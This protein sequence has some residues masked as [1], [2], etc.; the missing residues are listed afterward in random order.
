MAGGLLLKGNGLNSK[1]LRKAGTGP[2]FTAARGEALLTGGTG[3]RIADHLNMA[4]QR[5]R[6]LYYMPFKPL[7]HPHPSG[8]LVIGTELFQFLRRRGH[9]IRLVSRLRTRWIYWKPWQW[10]RI[11]LEI[12]RTRRVVQ[13][14]RPH[15]WLTYHSYYKAPD[16]L[17]ALCAPPWGLPYAVFQG[18]YATKHRRNVKTRP[19]FYLNRYALQRASMI[20]T[21]KRRDETNLRRLMPRDRLRYIAPGIRLDRFHATAREDRPAWLQWETAILPVVLTAA[22]FR[23]GVKTAGVA[24]VIRACGSAARKGH[25]FRLVVCGDGVQRPYLERLAIE[26]RL[27]NVVHFTGQVARDQMPH[28][29]RH[30]DVFAFP[31]IQEGL[32]MVYLEAQAAG[33]PVVACSGWGAS[34]V[35][36][37]DRTGLLS[38]PHDGGQF[39]KDLVRLISDAAL[40]RNM[41][42]AAARHVARHHDLEQNYLALEASLRGLAPGRGR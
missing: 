9:D 42:V 26:E 32:G 6:I 13:S 12:N 31:G 21:N 19:G 40:R 30:T 41:G 23:P 24:R 28:V 16:V 27:G 35:V 18:V 22:M 20:F 5:M 36:R 38:D 25:R 29:Y 37:H 2:A 15:V 17:G 33:L 8:D 11:P 1:G 39:E 4:G 10:C 14:F 34:E 7:G 3:R